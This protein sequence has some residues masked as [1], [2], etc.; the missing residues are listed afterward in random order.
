MPTSIGVLQ[1]VNI[2]Y[3]IKFIALIGIATAGPLI[4][5]HSQWVTGPIV[6]AT[7]ILAVYAVGIR[8]ALLMGILPS[9]IALSSGLL[10][11]MLAPMVPFIILGNTLLV[12]MI[13]W[14]KKNYW[15]VLIFGA[16]AKY[17]LLFFTS[18][19]VIHL[20]VKQSLAITVSQMMSWPQ[21]MTA[22]MGGVIA[23]GAL[24]MWKRNYEKN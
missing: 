4:G 7:L 2:N 19:V 20:L 3:I 12:L 17:L 6:N 9:T 21:F 11:A 5:I 1:K 14:L 15:L 8:G 18:N 23:W 24:K 16:T 22:I 10:P 13:D